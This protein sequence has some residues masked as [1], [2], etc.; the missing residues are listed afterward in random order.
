[1]ELFN[2]LK[3]LLWCQIRNS[4]NYLE[5]KAR[6]YLEALDDVTSQICYETIIADWNFE[7]NMNSENERIQVEKNLEQARI[8]KEIYKNLTNNPLFHQWKNFKDPDLLR[9]VKKLTD[10]GVTSLPEDEYRQVS[11]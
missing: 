7:T 1:M 9:K 10:L 6:S 2:T 5:S 4:E 3:C 11:L 8:N